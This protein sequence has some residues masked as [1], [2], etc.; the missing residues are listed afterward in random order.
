MP[1][2]CLSHPHLHAQASILSAALLDNSMQIVNMFADEVLTPKRVN[3]IT[4]SRIV[5]TRLQ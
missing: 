2:S 3:L 1:H 4:N 5:S